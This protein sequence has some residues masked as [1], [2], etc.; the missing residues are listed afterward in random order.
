[1]TQ[2]VFD[3][4]WERE[5]ERMGE[6][7]RKKEDGDDMADPQWGVFKVSQIAIVPQFFV[8]FHFNPYF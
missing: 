1:M 8:K 2:A 4:S 3:E 7:E 5:I 6:K